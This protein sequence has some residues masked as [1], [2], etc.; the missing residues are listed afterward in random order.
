MSTE[1][2]QDD[3]VVARIIDL[4]DLSVSSAKWLYHTFI[5]ICTWVIDTAVAFFNWAYDAAIN[6]YYFVQ[7]ASLADYGTQLVHFYHWIVAV[8]AMARSWVLDTI[9]SIFVWLF[10]FFLAISL[11]VGIFKWLFS[12]AGVTK[13]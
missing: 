8:H 7:H 3:W 11:I 4:Y 13:R 1:D 5:S 2:N 12:A 6:T 10:F 9:W